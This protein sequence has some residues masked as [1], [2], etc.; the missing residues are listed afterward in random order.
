MARE[1]HE[2]MSIKHILEISFLQKALRVLRGRECPT[3]TSLWIPTHSSSQFKLLD[4]SVSRT[5]PDENGNIFK[6]WRGLN[7]KDQN[8]LCS[9][10]AKFNSLS[11]IELAGNGILHLEQ[12][13]QLER[14]IGIIYVVLRSNNYTLN[15]FWYSISQN[16][17]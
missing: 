8:E 12:A 7:K 6:T 2:G 16:L 17:T 10:G 4:S 3:R 9:L 14:Q 15:D 11:Q 5:C 1:K 13:S